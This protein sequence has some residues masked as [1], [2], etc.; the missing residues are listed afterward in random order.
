MNDMD[1]NNDSGPGGPFSSVGRG[2]KV[3][4]RLGIKADELSFLRNEIQAQGHSSMVMD[5]G[6]LGEPA[7]APDIDHHQVANA[8]GLQ[9]ADV[10]ALGDENLAMQSMARGAAAI[11]SRLRASSSAVASDTRRSASNSSSA[12]A[13]AAPCSARYVAL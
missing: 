12:T 7:I 9:L 13:T 3:A 2:R 6:V 5:V 8:A 10:A 1:Q 4:S 11:A